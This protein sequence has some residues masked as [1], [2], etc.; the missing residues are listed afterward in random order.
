MVKVGVDREILDLIRRVVL[1]EA[2]GLGV[3]VE[4]IILFG[5]R[6]RGDA[7]EDSDWDIL[8][9][10][11]G[12]VGWRTRMR[13]WSKLYMRLYELLGGDV[14][15]IIMDAERLRERRGLWGSLE[16]AAERE[17]VVV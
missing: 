2:G 5:S 1:E 8:I 7:R 14:D 12:E 11:R 10:V 4:R 17:G 16:Y 3:T 6:A 9:V 15:V 13:F